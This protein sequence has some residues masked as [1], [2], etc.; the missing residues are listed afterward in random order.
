[1]WGEVP[2]ERFIVEDA[3]TELSLL[4]QALLRGLGIVENEEIVHEESL[5]EIGSGNG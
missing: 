5:V 2:V 3:L 4:G 1:M